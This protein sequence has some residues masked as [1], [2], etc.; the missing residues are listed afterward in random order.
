M[1]I[2]TE[3]PHC[4]VAL[5]KKKPIPSEGFSVFSSLSPSATLRSERI[6]GWK[7]C[8]RVTAAGN[9]E[10]GKKRVESSISF[11][12]RPVMKRAEQQPSENPRW[13]SRK[14]NKRENGSFIYKVDQ[15]TFPGTGHEIIQPRKGNHRH[16]F[17]HSIQCLFLLFFLRTIQFWQSK[18]KKKKTIQ[19]KPISLNCAP[20]VGMKLFFSLAEFSGSRW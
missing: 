11:H 4:P 19:R 8:R 16:F 7:V 3:M 5:S 15:S 9:S 17:H 12:G 2:N 18:G 10:R 20:K 14:K 13:S 6:D 1:D